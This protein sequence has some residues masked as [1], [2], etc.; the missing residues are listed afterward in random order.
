MATK[1]L[2]V[3]FLFSS[4]FGFAHN[5][6]YCDDCGS[7]PCAPCD[8]NAPLTNIEN[9]ALYASVVLENAI[10]ASTYVPDPDI[11]PD[12][13]A[14]VVTCMD[15]R[16]DPLAIM[17]FDLG[18][19]D[20]I[21][22]AGGRVTEDVIRSLVV[23][24]KL[25]QTNQWFVIQHTDCGMQ[26]FT[27]EVMC[28]LLAGTVESAQLIHNCNTTLVPLENNDVCQWQ[29]TSKCCGKI[30]GEDY[31]RVNW[32][33]INHGLIDSVTEDVKKIVSHPLVPSNIPVYG[34]IFDVATGLLIP[35]PEANIDGR[36]VPLVC[37]DHEPQVR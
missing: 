32:H 8:P 23:S 20:I 24:H 30:E 9:S 11:I 16:M 6:D 37:P 12:D 31:E 27:D 17:G 5:R 15:T 28:E 29:N 34:F 18:D 4:F 22:N 25:L 33:I 10:Y 7:T 1:I 3:I 14:A 26:K 21:R 13:R 36:A 35:V 2:T 19:A